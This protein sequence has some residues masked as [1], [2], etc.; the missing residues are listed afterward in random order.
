MQIKRINI[1]NL[2]NHKSSWIEP[3]EDLNIFFGPNGTGKTTVLEAI[4]IACLSKT[5]TNTSDAALIL[6]NEEGYA[7]SL[8]AISHLE[9]PYTIEVNYS[10]GMRKKISNT[11]GEGLNPK[12]IIGIIPLVYLSPDQK[13]ITSGSPEYRRDFIDRILAQSSRT[14]LD[15]L[16]KFRKVLKQRNSM[17]SA[18]KRNEYFDKDSYESWTN[19]FID[20][21]AKIVLKRSEFLMDFNKIFKQVY[22]EISANSENVNLYYEPHSISE[23]MSPDY[24]TN[25]KI[26]SELEVK[27]KTRQTA[28]LARGMTLFGPQKD[29]VRISIDEGLARERASQGQHKSLLISLIF[30]EF[31]YLLNLKNE[32]PVV[33]LDDIFSELD[34]HRSSLVLERVLNRNAQTFITLTNPNLINREK[35][36]QS[37]VSYFKLSKGQISIGL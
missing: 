34:E 24:L 19:L 6:Q 11:Y 29:E 7:I 36:V 20:L 17:L 21:A 3:N 15:N 32:I 23:A 2:R 31:E 22:S 35:L 12:D 18:F 16:M 9:L 28:E 1:L 13:N 25:D 37:K 27:S 5:F 4:S 14:Y 33:L 26:R 10:V 8:E 30:A